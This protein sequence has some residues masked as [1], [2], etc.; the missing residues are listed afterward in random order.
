M[1]IFGHVML[2]VMFFFYVALHVIS[3]FSPVAVQPLL[4]KLLPTL[5]HKNCKCPGAAF[6]SVCNKG[7]K[8]NEKK[9][10]SAA[11]LLMRGCHSGQLCVF[12]L[13]EILLWMSFVFTPRTKSF[14]GKCINRYSS[15]YWS[16]YEIIL[17]NNNTVHQ[18]NSS[19]FMTEELSK[20]LVLLQGAVAYL[21]PRRQ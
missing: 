16:H 9:L 10:L 15:G 7:T 13:A 17:R 11:P 1:F 18:Q 5:H 2:Q 3:V 14:L 4:K 20:G 12:D 19:I 8:N 21:K 6:V